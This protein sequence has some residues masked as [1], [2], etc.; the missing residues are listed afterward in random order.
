MC[1]LVFSVQ[2]DWVGSWQGRQVESPCVQGRAASLQTVRC[3]WACW[4]ER[5]EASL[6]TQ[7]SFRATCNLWVLSSTLAPELLWYE[8][9]SS[10]GQCIVQCLPSKPLARAAGGSVC[11]GGTE[12]S[13]REAGLGGLSLRAP[14]GSSWGIRPG[15]WCHQFIILS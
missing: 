11:L 7:L 6:V 12:E 2:S 10:P 15:S 4:S 14:L 9:A 13:A 8:P 3:S 1:V 5:E